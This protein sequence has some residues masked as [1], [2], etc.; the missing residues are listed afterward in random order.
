MVVGSRCLTVLT[1]AAATLV[2]ACA[3]PA[4]RVT[5]VPRVDLVWPAPPEIP[6]IRFLRTLSDPEDIGIKDGFF[7]GLAAFFKGAP[8]KRTTAPFGIHKTNAGRLYVVDTVQ[9]AVQVFDQRKSEHYWF[10]SD[11]IDGFDNPIGVVADEKG[12][13]YVSDSRSNLI[14]VFDKHGKRYI[15]AIGR[16]AVARPTGLAINQATGELLV[17]DTLASQ[18]VAFETKDFTV[19]RFVGRDGTG[20]E[21]FHYPTNIAVS[22]DGLIYVTD[23]MNFRIQVLTHDLKF[24]RS[25]GE[26]GDGPGQFS[27]PKGVAVDSEGHV[28]VVDALFDNVQIFDRQGRLLLAFG[29]PGSEPGKF[30]LPNEIFIDAQDRIYVSDAY[31]QRIQVFQYLK[32]GGGQ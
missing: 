25:F 1:V 16:G 20:R 17:A 9:Q 4:P 18:I 11:P 3:D 12:R 13:V 29:S 2:A 21:A 27:R 19:T 14:H 8:E 31:N 6:R 23:S 24:L 32:Q 15:K 7:G 5:A 26:V 30:W 10:P 28:Y 22:P